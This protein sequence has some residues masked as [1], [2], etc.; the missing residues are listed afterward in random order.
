LY[1]TLPSLHLLYVTKTVSQLPFPPS[2]VCYK[3]CITTS[4][5]SIYCMLQ[6]LYHN[7]PSLHLLYFTKTVS[8]HSFDLVEFINKIIVSMQI[9]LCSK[10]IH[11]FCNITVFVTYSRWREGLY[12]TKTVSQ[13]PFPPSTVCYKNCI[14]TPLPSIYCMLQKLCI[15]T[16][17]SLQA[18]LIIISL[19]I[20]LFSP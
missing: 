11:S 15:T 9:F 2:T 16:S 13:L 4:L 5:P 10:L 17:P 6:K 8:P 18:E 12:V 7:S 14:T 20:K 19:K 3:N 1:H